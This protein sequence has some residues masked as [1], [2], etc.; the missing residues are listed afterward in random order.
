MYL[1]S[2]AE[3]GGE[4]TAVPIVRV[5]ERLSVSTVSAN[6]MM[7]RLALQG[8]IKHLPYKGI[9]LTKAGNSLANSVIRRQ[10]L[11]ECFLVDHLKLS[12][13]DSFDLACDLEHATAKE[14]TEALVLFLGDPKFCPHGNP[15]PDA[16]GNISAPALLPLSQ[17][18][19]RDSAVIRAITPENSEVLAYFFERKIV[20][21]TPFVLVEIAPLEGPLTIELNIA[22]K[23]T[24]VALGLNLA[25]LVLVERVVS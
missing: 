12:W 11:W 10:R 17:L 23:T 24:Y 21:G 16:K 20:P 19:I 1:K 15:I 4:Q 2:L 5:A 22:D 7:K 9:I 6:E 13:D 8:L 14:V 3:L 25:T 18:K